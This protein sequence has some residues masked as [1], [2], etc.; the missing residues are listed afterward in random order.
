MNYNQ[1]LIHIE[2]MNNDKFN[3]SKNAIRFYIYNWKP[4][5]Y[6]NLP[7]KYRVS[8][9]DILAIEVI[10]GTYNSH[11]NLNWEIQGDMAQTK[12]WIEEYFRKLTKKEVL[13][14][15]SVPLK[16]YLWKHKT[17]AENKARVSVKPPKENLNHKPKKSIKNK[18]PSSR[19]SKR[20]NSSVPRKEVTLSL[21]LVYFL[22]LVTGSLFFAI[23]NDSLSIIAYISVLTI[24]TSL[25]NNLR[26]AK[27]SKILNILFIFLSLFIANYS[28]PFFLL[29]IFSLSLRPLLN[30]V[31]K[32]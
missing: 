23:Q 25:F 10:I 31:V 20:L 7:K 29:I 19:T 4:F 6:Q 21:G 18:R 24:A 27:H 16:K 8:T 2:N 14:M 12:K 28:L 22:L 1:A 32:K 9:N 11:N 13:S 17:E 5:V 30:V 3:R 26:P 15:N